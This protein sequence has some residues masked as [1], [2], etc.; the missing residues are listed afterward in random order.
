MT[1]AT[2]L[3]AVTTNQHDHTIGHCRAQ[4]HILY[5]Q[6]EYRQAQAAQPHLEKP[7]VSTPPCNDEEWTESQEELTRWGIDASDMPKS[8][9]SQA[10]TP[11]EMPEQECL[12]I[13]DVEKFWQ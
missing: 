6:T 7:V 10:P 1:A 5:S 8:D 11:S 13:E 3:V 12:R 2:E 4:R 9:S